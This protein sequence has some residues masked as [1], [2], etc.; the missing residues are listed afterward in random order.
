[1]TSCLKKKCK[2]LKRRIFPDLRQPRQTNECNS[3][4]ATGVIGN[5]D[6]ES[7]D[8]GNLDKTL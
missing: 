8:S 5:L 7:L 3:N 4:I 6:Y 2:Q 1:M